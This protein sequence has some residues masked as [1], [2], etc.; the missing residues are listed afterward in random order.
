MPN[1]YRITEEERDTLVYP[2]LECMDAQ[3]LLDVWLLPLVLEVGGILEEAYR[4]SHQLFERG[5]GEERILGHLQHK[6]MTAIDELEVVKG[7]IA[8]C[9]NM[10]SD[11]ESRVLD[12]EEEEDT[13]TGKVLK[14]GSVLVQ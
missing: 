11:K 6:L 14:E 1:G 9:C 8:S 4:T 12:G 7:W 3:E 2:R 5:Q 13:S 10:S